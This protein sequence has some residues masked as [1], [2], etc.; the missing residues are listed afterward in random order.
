MS[1][2]VF[3]KQAIMKM[4]TKRE[5]H[6][7]LVEMANKELDGLEKKKKALQIEL[8]DAIVE[9]DPDTGKDVII[10]IRA[11]TGGKE[12]SLFAGD[13]FRMYSKYIVAK[14]WKIEVMDSHIAEV[15]ASLHRI[16][17]STSSRASLFPR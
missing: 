6:S 12:A 1:L 7:E 9:E 15:G 3:C 2:Q 17:T 4:K 14:G 13:L 5:S 10:E 11:G 8:E 16:G